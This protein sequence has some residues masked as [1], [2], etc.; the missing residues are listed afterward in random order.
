MGKA[1]QC[2]TEHR[3]SLS[4]PFN[5]FWIPLDSILGFHTL[6]GVTIFPVE[7][8]LQPQAS[9]L[10]GLEALTHMKQPDGSQRFQMIHDD[11]SVSKCFK[12]VSALC[13]IAPLPSES[14]SHNPP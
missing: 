7:K 1:S 11:S 4:N 13:S 3:T 6:A 8:K 14:S 12:R 5:A 2:L 9:T 10:S